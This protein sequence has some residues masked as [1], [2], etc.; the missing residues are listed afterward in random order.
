MLLKVRSSLRP[1]LAEIAFSQPT[2]G[3]DRQRL[4]F[5]NAESEES[6]CMTGFVMGD[7]EAHIDRAF[8]FAVAYGTEQICQVERA[9]SGAR[10]PPRLAHPALDVGAGTPARCQRHG[11]KIGA[12]KLCAEMGAENAE[13]CR[14]VGQRD[15]DVTV[16]AAGAHQ[17]RIE[18]SGIV[19]GGDNDNTFAP[20]ET[21]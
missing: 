16:E 18:P 12:L 1:D 13:K 5:G 14:H 7:T 19:T 8:G 11:A 2:A 20:F 4:G 3:A 17:R 10:H 6:N 15:G 21:V 9:G